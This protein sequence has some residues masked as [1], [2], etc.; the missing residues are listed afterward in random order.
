MNSIVP[1]SLQNQSNQNI[2][3]A[4]SPD[5]N[6]DNQKYNPQ[7]TTQ[8]ILGLFFG[9]IFGYLI[10]KGGVANYD[11]LMGALFL[12][13]FTVMKI[14]LSAILTGMI[15]IFTMHRLGLVELHIKPTRYAANIIGGLV[16][17]IGFGLLGYCPGTGAAAVGQGNYDAIAGVLGLLAGSYFYAEMSGYINTTIMKWGDRGKLIFPDVM[18][19]SR[20]AFI[21]YFAIFLTISLYLLER[22]YALF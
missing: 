21:V 11:V 17:G 3:S 8:L 6:K 5:L 18:G 4:E 16:F 13:D 20:K 12:T 22:F 7:N 9:I 1:D 14:I 19:V 10:Q 2:D 15:G